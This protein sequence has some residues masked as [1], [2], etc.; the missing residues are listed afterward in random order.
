MKKMKLYIDNIKKMELLKKK[1]PK[2]KWASG[3]DILRFN[4]GF[5]FVAY[6][7]SFN[8]MT[9]GSFGDLH[10]EEKREILKETKKFFK[11]SIEIE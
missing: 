9:Y 8:N 11:R 10:L 4:P 1:M 2:V 6:I 3:N 7:N 5:P